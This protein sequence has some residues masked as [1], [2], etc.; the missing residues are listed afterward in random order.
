VQRINKGALWLIVSKKVG[1]EGVSTMDGSSKVTEIDFRSMKPDSGL[2]G[3][4]GIFSVS[5]LFDGFFQ[6]RL[7]VNLA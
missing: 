3:S 6:N 2:S 4:I 1:S 5:I 7:V